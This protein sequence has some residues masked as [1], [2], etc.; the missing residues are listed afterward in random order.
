MILV[1]LFSLMLWLHEPKHGTHMYTELYQGQYL[2]FDTEDVNIGGLVLRDHSPIHFFANSYESI[3][4][5]KFKKEVRFG[6]VSQML[7]CMYILLK[8]RIRLGRS[9]VMLEILSS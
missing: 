8:Y 3:I 4:I 5:S 9:G 6:P 2:S 1:L 7:M